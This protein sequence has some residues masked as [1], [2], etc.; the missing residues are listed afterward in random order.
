MPDYKTNG[1]T[2]IIGVI[3]VTLVALVIVGGSKRISVITSGLVPI[4]AFT[5]IFVAV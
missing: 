3:L 4:M 2:L 5:Y 1:A